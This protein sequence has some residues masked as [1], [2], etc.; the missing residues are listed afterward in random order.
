[1]S[2]GA[3]LGAL[4]PA[5][6]NLFLHVG[7]AESGG[8]HAISSLVV[9]A[10]LGDR[11]KLELTETPRLTLEGRF[12]D[13]LRREPAGGNLVLRAEALFRTHVDASLCPVAWTLDKQIPVAA[14][15]GGGS[16]D[17]AAALRLLQRASGV[18]GGGLAQ[19]AQALG[20]DGPMCLA[21]R[22]AIALGFGHDL[23]PAPSLP[24]IWT[25]LVNPMK[26][27]P[28]GT[29]Y[30]AFDKAGASGRAETPELPKRFASAGQ[31]CAFLREA[32]RNDLQAPAGSVEPSINEALA[33]LG[34]GSHTLLTRMSGSGATCFA[35]CASRNAALALAAQVSG[36]K[37]RWWVQACTLG[38]QEG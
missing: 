17:G 1:M 25:V 26:P 7:P 31:L 12:A 20:A 28:T 16:A 14:G 15:L 23:Q 21:S 6:I 5:K 27:C 3:G 34:A 4:A 37:P 30:R 11:L 32:T 10:D 24:E 38:P 2:A 22:P 18:A 13:A 29:V 9:F 8:L 35:L 33:L 19:A 36:L